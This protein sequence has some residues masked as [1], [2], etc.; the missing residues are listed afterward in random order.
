MEKT[1]KSIIKEGLDLI[2]KRLEKRSVNLYELEDAVFQIFQPL[3]K[4]VFE[5]A[6]SSLPSRKKTRECKHC[7][8]PASEL[9]SEGIRKKKS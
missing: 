2:R 8:A 5:K 1:E 3:Q 7:S 6:A 4:E 9:S